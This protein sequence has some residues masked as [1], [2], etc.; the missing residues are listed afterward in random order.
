ML[1]PPKTLRAGTQ[2][3]LQSPRI[4]IK[5]LRFL[6]PA[7]GVGQ[8]NQNRSHE[9]IYVGRTFWTDIGSEHKTKKQNEKRWKNGKT[10]DMMHIVE[11]WNNIANL[12]IKYEKWKKIQYLHARQKTAHPST[13]S[14][15]RICDIYE[16]LKFIIEQ[17]KK[18]PPHRNELKHLQRKIFTRHNKADSQKQNW[19]QN[20]S[21][22]Q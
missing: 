7:L 10:K 1:S 4:F 8:T 14:P 15:V 2:A 20:E 13:A 12:L 6:T 22:P 5:I 19:K 17:E 9:N 21:H 16:S 3:I 11:V 18:A